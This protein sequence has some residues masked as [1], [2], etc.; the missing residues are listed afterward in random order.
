MKKLKPQDTL[1]W[2]KNLLDKNENKFHKACIE[3]WDLVFQIGI[4]NDLPIE[5]APGI[6]GMYI[7]DTWD[8][9]ELQNHNIFPE[10]YFDNHYDS[11][12]ILIILNKNTP[13]VKAW[14]VIL[15]E[16]GHFISDDIIGG[17]PSDR[18][19]SEM[20]AWKFV[21]RIWNDFT[22][23]D[24][25]YEFMEKCVRGHVMFFGNKYGIDPEKFG[26]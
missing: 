5:L 9:K 11:P 7:S 6:F 23:K 13:R 26:N 10:D 12:N 3:S 8:F 22:N 17:I 16:L 18:I 14:A 2:I 4:E 1:G 15:H 19:T 21:E 25:P 24:L 20:E